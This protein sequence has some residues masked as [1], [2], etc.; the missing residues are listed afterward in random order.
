[1]A[2]RLNDAFFCEW[3]VRHSTYLVDLSA[4]LVGWV[5]E[6]RVLGFNQCG[7]GDWLERVAVRDF[8]S[9]REVRSLV[10]VHDEVHQAIRRIMDLKREGNLALAQDE[11]AR[12]GPKCEELVYLFVAV[13]DLV[14]GT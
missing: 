8:G 13:E 1:M 4:F 10:G 2:E 14:C 5:D 6:R 7:F 12:L 11:L 3:R 9:H